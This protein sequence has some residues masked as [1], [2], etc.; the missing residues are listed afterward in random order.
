MVFSS[1]IPIVT[2]FA[3]VMGGCGTADKTSKFV[4]TQPAAVDEMKSSEPAP[5]SDEREPHTEPDAINTASGKI[6]TFDEQ[7]YYAELVEAVF[8]EHCAGHKE[9]SIS[10]SPPGIPP[11]LD[12]LTIIIEPPFE[13]THRLGTQSAEARFH[14]N[15]LPIRSDFY[16]KGGEIHIETFTPEW[17]RASFHVNFAFGEIRGRV[18]TQP[19]YDGGY[20]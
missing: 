15:R 16:S 9:L 2:L 18:E 4:S 11:A 5:L 17:L 1:K 6:G 8:C 20:E 3:I 14:T 19:K 13:G 12:C 7:P 10:F